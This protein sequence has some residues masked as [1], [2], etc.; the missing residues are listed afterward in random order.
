VLSTRQT[1]TSASGDGASDTSDDRARKQALW[2]AS[3]VASNARSSSVGRVCRVVLKR[4]IV[5]V[6]VRD[7][8]FSFNR[9]HMALIRCELLRGIGC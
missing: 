6:T 7:Q 2:T 4:S 9:G 1:L 8:R 3:D 5:L